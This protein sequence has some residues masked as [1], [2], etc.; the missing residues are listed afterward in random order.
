LAFAAEIT[1]SALAAL[2]VNGFLHKTCLPA[3]IAA[4]HCSL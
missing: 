4:K 1:S 2:M 3:A